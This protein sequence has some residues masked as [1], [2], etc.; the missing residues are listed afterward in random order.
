MAQEVARRSQQTVQIQV[1]PAATFGDEREH[2]ALLRRGALDLSV[3]GDLVIS[4]L[5]PAYLA[6]NMP[7]LYRNVAH[8]LATYAG[9]LGQEMRASMA[10]KGLETLSWHHV[11]VRVLTANRPVRGIDDLKGLKLRLPPD[12]AWVAVWNALGASTQ[13]LP[14][15]ELPAALK[16]GKIDA[17]ENP[18]NFIR[19]S[20]LYE[21]QKYLMTTHHMPQRQFV[22]ASQVRWQQLPKATRELLSQAA[23]EASRW[24]IETAEAEERKDLEWLLTEGGMTRVVFDAGNVVQRLDAVATELGGSAARGVYQRILATP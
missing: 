7:F 19:A 23:I 20:K 13:Q 10:S 1:F 6:V 4:K 5:E 12:A 3:T 8:A 2:L 15:T 21:H 11:G 16:L 18:P 14:F 9:P 22:L 24:A 17:Q